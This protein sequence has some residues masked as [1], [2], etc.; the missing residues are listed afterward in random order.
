M[1]NWTA[2]H[3]TDWICVR[4]ELGLRAEA[5]ES[6]DEFFRARDVRWEEVKSQY[7]H[8]FGS[9][10]L[11]IDDEAIGFAYSFYQPDKSRSSFHDFLPSLSREVGAIQE[12]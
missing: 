9:H 7:S 2:T 10:G 4:P 1:T 6:R 5:Y 12:V 11:E 3:Y 8:V